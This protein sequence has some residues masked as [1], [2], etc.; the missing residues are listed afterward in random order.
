[1]STS[2]PT[3]QRPM[4]SSDTIR[5][6]VGVIAFMLPVLAWIV[7]PFAL[8]PSISA[9]Y[10]TAVRDIFVGLLFV[11]GAFLFT[12]KGHSSQE[13]WMANLAAL[14]AIVAAVFPTSCDTCPSN[15]VST[16][17]FFAG[18]IMFLVTAYFC[19]W[20]FKNAA[21]D[22]STKDKSSKDESSKEAGRRVKFYSFCGWA[23]IV[24]LGIL[25]AAGLILNAEIKRISAITFI[26]EFI[27]LWLFSAAWMVAAKWLPWFSN[28]EE[29]PHLAKELELDKLNLLKPGRK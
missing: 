25:A 17:H 26:G 6:L 19:L 12:Y 3:E 29:R 10:Y 22:K 9:S 7:S 28:K 13:S 27:M 11:L 8:L 1:M 16:I 18:A 4:F 24:C 20:P 14:A 15:I 2:K 5:F 21:K 23:I